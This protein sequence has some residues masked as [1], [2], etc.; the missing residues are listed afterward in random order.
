MNDSKYNEFIFSTLELSR[1][2]NFHTFY[3]IRN[4]KK[5]EP[6]K[7]FIEV[8]KNCWLFVSQN[9]FYCRKRI[10]YNSHHQLFRTLNFCDLIINKILFLNNLNLKIIIIFNVKYTNRICKFFV[11]PVKQLY[12][13]TSRLVPLFKVTEI[14]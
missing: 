8:R 3:N 4:R 12:L 9:Y 1:Q 11:L 13:I 7:S 5:H 6:I 14:N 2:L 10:L